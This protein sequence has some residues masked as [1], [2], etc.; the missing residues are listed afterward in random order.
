MLADC[1]IVESTL[2]E[3]GRLARLVP[4]GMRSRPARDPDEVGAFV[5][6]QV[7]KSFS[8]IM[9]YLPQAAPP[10]VDAI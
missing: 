8:S 4:P 2:A 3:R 6:G 5:H 1:Y 7:T 9:A 10:G